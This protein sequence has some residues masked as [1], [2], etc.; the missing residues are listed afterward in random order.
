VAYWLDDADYDAAYKRTVLHA[1]ALLGGVLLMKFS[2][3][4][5][6]IS[7]IDTGS[8]IVILCL[9]FSAACG[10]KGAPMAP[11]AQGEWGANQHDEQFFA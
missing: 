6:R 8:M 4:F 10:R 2:S 5:A 3:F 9:V 1:G 7:G 11:E